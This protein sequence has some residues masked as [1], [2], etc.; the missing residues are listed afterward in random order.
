MSSTPAGWYPQ[1]DG[2]QRYWD[3]ERWT[4]HFAPGVGSSANVPPEMSQPAFASPQAPTGQVPP[5]GAAG[6]GQSVAGARQ[7][8]KKKRFMIPAGIVALLVVGSALGGGGDTPEVTEA[9]TPAPS[10]SAIL[11]SA[12]APSAAAKPSAASVAPEPSTPAP[13]KTPAPAKPELSTAQKNAVR[14]AENYLSFAGFSQKGL[15]KQLDF[16]G[17]STTDS[18]AAISTM[19]VNWNEEAAQ[20]AKLYTDMTGFSRSSL[21]KQL[22]FDGY[23]KSQAQHGAS[24]VGL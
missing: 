20:S 8:F 22:E 4:E 24:S 15:I 11:P 23:T 7:W 2:R 18:Q 16:E 21:I 9:A 5:F 12:S 13:T 6:S 19:D 14:S 1:E 17:Y 10:T 3:G